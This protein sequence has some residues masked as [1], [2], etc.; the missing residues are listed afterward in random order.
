[1]ELQDIER[2]LVTIAKGLSDHGV[3]NCEFVLHGG[4]PLLLPSEYFR[5]IY[6]LQKQILGE[7]GITFNNVV[8]SNLTSLKDEHIQLIKDGVIS[9][10]G[11]SIDLFGD[12]RVNVAGR[13]MDDKSLQN[14]ERLAE[15]GIHF[16]GISVLSKKTEPY[17]EQMYRFFSRHNLSWRL[18]PIDL[19]G[20]EGQHD[21]NVLSAEDIRAV[22]KSLFEAWL[23]SDEVIKLEPL[24]EYIDAAIAS[25]TNSRRT[26]RFDKETGDC[27]F[28]VNTNG[29]VYSEADA[30]ESRFS[31]GNLLTDS[32][33]ELLSSPAR[34]RAIDRARLITASTCHHC[35]YYG[36]CNGFRMA[37]ATTERLYWDENGNISC[38]VI[39]PMIDYIKERLTE[40][41]VMECAELAEAE[42]A[43]VLE[44]H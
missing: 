30:Y 18:L 19:T 12:E 11:V 26:H 27:L 34:R 44:R 4:E 17:I 1:M 39:K 21:N 20:F 23:R 38:A 31:Y 5:A 7:R 8:Q 10:I 42:G 32:F 33:D 28:I 13:N 14:M 40:E 37:E 43:R 25:L 29:D 22:F 41:R 3:S 2:M 15:A 9:S 35:P 6:T 16:G 36:H 24:N